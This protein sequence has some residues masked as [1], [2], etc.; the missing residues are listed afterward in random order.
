[1][2]QRQ[3][4]DMLLGEL[5]RKFPPPVLNP[6]PPPNPTESPAQPPSAATQENNTNS[7]STSDGSDFKPPEKRAKW[8]VFEK[9]DSHLFPNVSMKL[10]IL[11]IFYFTCNFFTADTQ[12]YGIS[13]FISGL[14]RQYWFRKSYK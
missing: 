10:N 3:R 8:N 12:R 7:K 4:V 11:I 14:L 1:M 9:F 2:F 6:I 13:K 5:L